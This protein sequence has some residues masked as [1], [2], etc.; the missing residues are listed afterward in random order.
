[1]KRIKELKIQIECL[2]KLKKELLESGHESR[3]VNALLN[4]HKRELAKLEKKSSDM[5]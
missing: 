2:E 3:R 1:M 4:T 5:V